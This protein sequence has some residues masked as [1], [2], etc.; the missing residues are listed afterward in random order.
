[1]TRWSVDDELSA[2]IGGAE[3]TIVAQMGGDDRAAESAA[4]TAFDRRRSV[5]LSWELR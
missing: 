2:A 4:R 5:P 1:L 3:P